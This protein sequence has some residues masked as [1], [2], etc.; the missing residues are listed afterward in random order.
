MV[1]AAFEYT[2]FS[3]QNWCPGD[4]WSSLTNR[5]LDLGMHARLYFWEIYESDIRLELHRAEMQ[6]W[7]PMENID[8]SAIKL[9]HCEHLHGHIGPADVVLWVMTLGIAFA[10]QVLFGRTE[11]YVSYVPVEF[12]IKM[13]RP[14]TLP[15][16]VPG[17]V[18]ATS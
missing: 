11:R 5:G 2:H 15:A 4:N 6:G 18:L 9:R 14:V 8:P 10:M 1:A 16:M 13:R 7:E 12:R 17:E 3:F